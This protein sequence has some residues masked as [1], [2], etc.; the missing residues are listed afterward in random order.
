MQ[1][2]YRVDGTYRVMITC[3]ITVTGNAGVFE[4]MRLLKGEMIFVR[5]GTAWFRARYSLPREIERLLL[6]GMIQKSY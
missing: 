3:W 5:N 2:I 1:S 6:L 4:Q